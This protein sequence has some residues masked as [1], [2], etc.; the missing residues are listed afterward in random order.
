M[1]SRFLFCLSTALAMVLGAGLVASM[2]VRDAIGYPA[3]TVSKGQ[4]PI[5]SVGGSADM[6]T[7]DPVTATV[8]TAPEDQDIIITDINMSGTSDYS[9]CSERW[10]V[11]FTTTGGEIVAAYTSGIG[12]SNDY[13][14]PDS[15]NLQLASGLRVP[16]GEGLV[17]SA[18]REAWGGSC[19]WSR[20][21]TIRWSL[22]GYAAQP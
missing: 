12:S 3:A 13:S 6:P 2:S 18:Y 20:V 14:Y 1:Y 4:N 17:M 19:S 15:L 7:G 21:A 8:I 22:A 16:A 10:P 5:V 11:S 9:G